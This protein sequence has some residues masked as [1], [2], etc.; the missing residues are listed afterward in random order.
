MKSSLKKNWVSPFIGISFLFVSVTGVLMLM[1][2]RNHA[3]NSLHEWMGVLFIIFGIFHL[4]LN[5]P[6]FI[7]YFSKKQG[8]IAIFV[9][10]FLA[11]IFTFNGL[12]NPSDHYGKSAK[13]GRYLHRRR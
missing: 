12:I 11:V 9:V 8:A 4:T 3:L 10:L 1:H 6:V 7:S 2:V 5:W 13:D